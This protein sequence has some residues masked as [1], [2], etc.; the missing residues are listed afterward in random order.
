MSTTK[1]RSSTQ[2][3]V[4]A[5]FALNLPT[6]SPT[7]KKITGMANGVAD[8]DGVN[9]SQLAAAVSGVGGAIHVPVADLAAAKAVAGST[10]PDGHTDRMI[11]LIETLGL[12]RYD[13][14]STVTSND[15]TIIRP[16]D[17]ASDAAPGRWLKIS[18]TLTDHNLLSGLQGGT[19]NEYYHLT[20]AE[21]AKLVAITKAS[22]AEIDTGTDDEKFV[23]SK[24]IRDSGVISTAKADEYETAANLTAI[25][26]ADLFLVEDAS[27]TVKNTKKNIKWEDLL[28]TLSTHFRGVRV[29]RA[30]PTGTIN[31]SNADF[32]I[33]ATIISGTEEVFVNG[34]LRNAGSGN[35][36]TILAA[37][38]SAGNTTIRFETGSIPQAT[39][40]ADGII[41][42]YSV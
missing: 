13:A 8:N 39:P 3:V 21:L 42:N 7:N 28:A 16:T 19:T 1:V 25:A 15:T 38:P 31:G 33:G 35:D 30:T 12:Y 11:M 24:A 6:Y 4:D 18:S 2:L 17:I 26:A 22:G 27:E 32:V 36:Y 29:Y 37:T 23:T 41:V 14:Q 34:I 5:D 40:F 10:A 20:A 9:M